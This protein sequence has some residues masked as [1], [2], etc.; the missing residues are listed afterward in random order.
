[1]G[2]EYQRR[3][4]MLILRAAQLKAHIAVKVSRGHKRSEDGLPAVLIP[5]VERSESSILC[6][7]SP[8]SQ[9]II[10]PEVP[11]VEIFME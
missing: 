4:R 9:N 1:M 8:S 2:K 11:A 5:T 10:I 3:T 7:P 6:S